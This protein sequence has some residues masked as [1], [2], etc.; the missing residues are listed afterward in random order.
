MEKKYFTLKNV[1]SRQIW[2]TFATN[3]PLLYSYV[4]ANGQNVVVRYKAGK[5]GFVILNPD[6]VLPKPPQA[7]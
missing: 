6:D 2:K 3:Y 5:D 7:Y 4:D 1:V